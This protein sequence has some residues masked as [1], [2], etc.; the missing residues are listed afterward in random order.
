MQKIKN[1]FIGKEF[2]QIIPANEAPKWK[3]VLKKTLMEGLVQNVE[4]ILVK[5]NRDQFIC[6]LSTTLIQEIDGRPQAFMAIIR[7]ISHRKKIEQQL[8]RTERMV[9]LG[10]M[11]SAMAHE[12]NQPLLSISLGIENL[13]N[14]I[15][16]L[17]VID[18][19]YLKNKTEKIFE[20]IQ[21]IGYIIDHVRAFSR[22]RDDYIVSSFNVNESI[23]NAVSMISQQYKHHGI[24]LS[25]KPDKKIGL[26]NGNTYR[27]EQVIL[28]LLNNAK[29]ALEEKTRVLKQEYEKTIDVSSCLSGNGI[30]ISIRD[31]GIGIRKEDI[32]KIMFPFYTTKDVGKGTG[33][34]LSISFGI[35]KELNGNIE[36]E[37]VPDKG[38]LFRITLPVV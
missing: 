7:D 15:Q 38:T 33:L 30:I 35:V 17:A 20:D 29:D 21:R 24:I 18:E 2:C 32:D 1:E 23:R 10:E 12:I 13:L 26:I 36:V 19:K 5:K 9:S 8:I 22:D 4:F 31:N 6:E 25:F 34:G 37:S 3:D 28:N 14:K 27:F 11:A 16:N